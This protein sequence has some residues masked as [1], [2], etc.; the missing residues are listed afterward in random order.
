MVY[1]INIIVP[2]VTSAVSYTA[3]GMF[4]SITDV[5]E[6]HIRCKK[7]LQRNQFMATQ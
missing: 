2:N 3:L 4:T 7:S 6:F 1:F 5:R